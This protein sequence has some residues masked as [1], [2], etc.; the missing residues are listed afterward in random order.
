MRSSRRSVPTAMAVSS[1]PRFATVIRGYAKRYAD[2]VVHGLPNPGMLC[3]GSCLLQL[4]FG[5]VEQGHIVM[6][7][8]LRPAHPQCVRLPLPVAD[9]CP[10]GVQHFGRSNEPSLLLI[11]GGHGW[12]DPTTL[13]QVVLP[14]L[15][16]G[17]SRRAREVLMCPSSLHRSTYRGPEGHF[18][19]HVGPW[20]HLRWSASGHR[21]RPN[22][23]LGFH[24]MRGGRG[25]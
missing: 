1:S 14:V 9:K 19:R 21:P 15:G 3:G 10:G 16:Q 18:R 7:A 2:L 17:M 6:N 8:A 12:R 25:T 22:S 23:H 4:T 5:H 11:G 24:P 20:Y 13:H